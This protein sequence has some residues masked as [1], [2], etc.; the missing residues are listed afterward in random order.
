MDGTACNDSNSCTRA[1][2]CVAGVCSGADPITCVASDAC[3]AAGTCN[4]TTGYCSNPV[5]VGGAC[6]IGVFDYDKAGRLV[7]DHGTKLAYDAYDQ[8][9]A[10]TPGI[11]GV[12]ALVNLPVTDLGA[13]AGG[14]YASAQDINLAGQIVGIA[15]DPSNNPVGFYIPGSGQPLLLVGANAAGAAFSGANAVNASGVVTGYA[16]IGGQQHLLRFT[17]PGTFEDLGTQGTYTSGLGIGDSGEIVG[18]YGISGG[19][20][21]FR[22]ANGFET[23]G[24]LGGNWSEARDV[25]NDGIVVGSSRLATTPTSPPGIATSG[26]AVIFDP[27]TNLPEDLNDLVDEVMSPGWVLH[28]AVRKAGDYI[29]GTGTLDGATR[30]YR[31]TLSS[32]VV[33]DPTDGALT[34]LNHVAMSGNAYGDAVGTGRSEPNGPL[35]AWVYVE[36]VGLKV[37]NDAI[38]STSGWTLDSAN[39]INEAGDVVGLGTHNGIRKPFR[40]RL[41]I[42]TNGVTGPMLA[43]VHTY[44]YDGLRTSTT[45]FSPVNPMTTAKSQ[46]WFTQDYTQTS[47]GKREHYVRIGDRIVAK[48]TMDP[49]GGAGFVL[50]ASST[51]EMTDDQR[52]S[53]RRHWEGALLLLVLGAFGATMAVVK[54]RRGWIPATVALVLAAFTV[55]SCEMFGGGAQRVA[56]AWTLFAEMTTYFHQGIAPGQTVTTGFTGG[57]AEERRYEPFGQPID[58]E[59]PGAMGAANFASE[60]QNILGKMTNPNTGWSYHGARWMMPQTARWMSPDPSVKAPD[61]KHLFA[62]WD[63]NPYAYVSQQPTLHWDPDGRDAV[64]YIGVGKG[65]K[66]RRAFEAVAS[67]LKAELT[68]KGVKTE[69]VS[70]YAKKDEAIRRIEKRGGKVSAAIPIAHGDESNVS[71]QKGADGSVMS[72]KRLDDLAVESKVAK[73][74]VVVSIACE[75]VFEE[76]HGGFDAEAGLRKRGIGVAG[77]D[78]TVNFYGDGNLQI[79]GDPKVR[80]PGATVPPVVRTPAVANTS[81]VQH[82][83]DAEKRVNK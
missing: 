38:L 35:K 27:I 65:E 17:P 10:V 73:G 62:P 42:R 29:Y 54:R 70:D 2:S 33:I 47:S 20:L 66:D 71:L 82:V 78:R 81:V 13:V 68:E 15:S 52:G 59:G 25:S 61:P 44:G 6:Q 32:G 45:T 9:M 1:D 53:G 4:P 31:M 3:H 51:Q 46:Y 48:V 23:L 18:V 7:R 63:A 41:P 11:T 26:H 36:G 24:D 72:D 56:R 77:F 8:L 55:T 57:V 40:L 67:K 76:R 79:K 50:P 69:I 75:T 30:A 43:E 5:V 14:T 37:L 16:S 64:I 34:A 74:G 22:Y 19:K 58:S 60:P 21:A 12:P 49:T 83:L 39:S 80:T 28:T